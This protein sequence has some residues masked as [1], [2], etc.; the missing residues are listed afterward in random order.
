MGIFGY[1]RLSLGRDRYGEYVS[2]RLARAA[3]DRL[4]EGHLQAEQTG[5]EALEAASQ[6]YLRRF[7][8]R[9]GVSEGAM[10]AVA[11]LGRGDRALAMK[12]TIQQ[13]GRDTIKRVIFDDPQL[14][15]TD[16][17]QEVQPAGEHAGWR[18][19]SGVAAC[20]SRPGLRAGLRVAGRVGAG[21]ADRPDEVIA[22]K[23]LPTARQV[24][25]RFTNQVSEWQQS[26]QAEAHHLQSRG[27]AMA[28]PPDL[29]AA[30]E[31]Q[32]QVGPSHPLRARLQDGF[33]NNVARSTVA[34]AAKLMAEVLKDFKPS[35]A[36]PIAKALAN[37]LAKLTGER[38][39]PPRGGGA[40]GPA[41]TGVRRMACALQSGS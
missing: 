1:A 11:L 25:L 17:R 3:V 22:Q 2:Q 28:L 33:A 10:K 16:G 41:D 40:I 19:D 7:N 23:G 5:E 6:D 31:T 4:V 20:R 32:P 39:R 24:L 26:L 35:F 36:D 14:A 9:L 21:C 34:E 29:A 18:T 30:L 27:G 12:Q 13:S 38:S 15:H 8:M 37:E